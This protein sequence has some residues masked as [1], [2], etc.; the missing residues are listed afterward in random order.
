MFHYQRFS[1]QKLRSMSQSFGVTELL[2]ILAIIAVPV[3]A[4]IALVMILCTSGREKKTQAEIPRARMLLT[5]QWL[6][7]FVG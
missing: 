2:L 5:W 3:I 1:Q 7:Q 4:G 6:A